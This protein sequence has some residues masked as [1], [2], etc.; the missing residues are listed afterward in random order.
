MKNAPDYSIL[1][2]T[3]RVANRYTLALL[4]CLLT[5]SA[6]CTRNGATGGQK[7][8]LMVGDIKEVSVPTRSDTTWQLNATSDNQEVV[9]VSRKQTIATVGS[10][11]SSSPAA[12]VV[13]LIKGVT[14]GT[15]SIVFSEKQPGADGAGTVKKRYRVTVV[16]Q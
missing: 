12:E 1:P 7:L 10:A 8:R 6:A 9:D 3:A 5:L 13:F 15:A 11:A 4:S 2:L 14:A 16:N